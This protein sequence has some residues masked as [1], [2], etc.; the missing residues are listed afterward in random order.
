MKIK[1]IRI[2]I[3]QTCVKTKQYLEYKSQEFS[4]KNYAL[5]KSH[6]HFSR[7]QKEFFNLKKENKTENLKN[8][9]ESCL[10]SSLLLKR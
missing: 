3:S 6:F 1:R 2:K 9:Q 5:N 8:N 7:K 4:S 10:K